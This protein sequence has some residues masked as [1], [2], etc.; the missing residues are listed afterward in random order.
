ME[1]ETYG[2]SLNSAY[3]VHVNNNLTS[4]HTINYETRPPS[5]RRHHGKKRQQNTETSN[6]PAQPSSENPDERIEVK[7]LP[8]DDN[9]GETTTI[10]CHGGN[11][12]AMTNNNDTSLQL[13]DPHD[14]H[15][16][17]WSKKIHRQK[18]SLTLS[19]YLI[20]LICLIALISP[21]FFLSLPYLLIP[22]RSIVIDDYSP[23]FTIIFKFIFLIF[24]SVLLL[25]RRRNSTHLP[26]IH[27]QK[28]ILIF[29]LLSILIVYWFYYVF[30]ILQPKVE[31]Y[32]RILSFSSTYE[33]LMIL[34]FVLTV[35][36][37]EI[38]WFYPKWIVKIVRSP[39]G[40]TRQYSIGKKKKKMKLKQTSSEIQRDH[41]K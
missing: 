39:D 17:V 13:N 22:R 32:R 14:D 10:T 4:S 31:P 3:P 34:L 27:A 23:L 2:S 19:H 5:S 33:D 36:V 40:Q 25:H 12:D 20:Y 41:S 18:S 7:I 29:I 1:P 38:R 11:E 35:L 26:R 28:S 16:N 15:G 24:G 21:I 37:L 9:W 6:Q 30:K 8:Q